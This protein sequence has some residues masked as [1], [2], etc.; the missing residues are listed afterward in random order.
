MHLR[1]QYHIKRQWLPLDSSSYKAVIISS[2]AYQQYTLTVD[3]VDYVDMQKKHVAYIQVH[4]GLLPDQTP[5]L[6][7]VLMSSPVRV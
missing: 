4:V 5:E 2:L 6:W 3:Y 1:N 7:H